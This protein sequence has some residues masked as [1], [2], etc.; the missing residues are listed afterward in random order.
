MECARKT[1]GNRT[2]GRPLKQYFTSVVCDIN[3]QGLSGSAVS[4]STMVM[5][6]VTSRR[7]QLLDVILNWPMWTSSATSSSTVPYSMAFAV[8]RVSRHGWITIH[9]DVWRLTT[10]PPMSDNDPGLWILS[11]CNLRRL[12]IFII[13]YIFPSSKFVHSKHFSCAVTIQNSNIGNTVS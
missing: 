13:Y 5:T 4:C 9:C 6:P 7:P 11:S 10:R 2:A 3:R 1:I 8:Y 12:T